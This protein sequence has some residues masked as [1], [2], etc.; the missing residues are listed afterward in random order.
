MEWKLYNFI[1]LKLVIF[2]TLVISIILA[3][4]SKT[5]FNQFLLDKHFEKKNKQPEKNEH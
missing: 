3:V 1:S 5:K 2:N 4:I